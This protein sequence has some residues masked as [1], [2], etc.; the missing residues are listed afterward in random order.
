MASLLT[1]ATVTIP[2]GS[3]VAGV[4]GLA[5]R[6]RASPLPPSSAAAPRCGWLN[7]RNPSAGARRYDCAH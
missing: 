5:N 2:K 3:L 1:F 7:R 4:L 6:K